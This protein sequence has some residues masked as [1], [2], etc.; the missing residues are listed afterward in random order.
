MLLLTSTSDLVRLTPG[1]ASDIEVHASWVD[2]SGSTVTPGRTN[3]ASI[4]GTSQTTIVGSPAA[5]TYRN[6]KLLSIRNNHASQSS[7]VTV[8]HTDGTTAETLIAVTLLA[9]ET[10][11]RNYVGKWVHYTANG[12]PYTT[13]YPYA[14]AAEMETA[15]AIDRFVNPSVQ[16]RHPGHPKCYGKVTVSGGAPTLQT[17]YNMTSIADTAQGRITY[18]IATD[19]SGANWCCNASVERASTTLTNANQ[20]MVNIELGGQAAGTVLLECGCGKPNATDET[21]EDPAAWHMVG[22]GDHA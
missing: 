7:V 14:S 17:A 22:M 15:T 9:G 18:T 1:T 20:R 2:L 21:L 12:V 13:A 11:V 4:T 19:F 16:H 10:L 5:S 6:V 3:T 8:D